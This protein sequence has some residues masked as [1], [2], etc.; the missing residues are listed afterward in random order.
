M[1]KISLLCISIMVGQIL[2]NNGAV[3]ADT[4]FTESQIENTENPATPTS[5]V[6]LPVAQKTTES[7]STSL[8]NE[9]DPSTSSDSQLNTTEGMTTET[10]TIPSAEATSKTTVS[11][12]KSIINSVWGTSPVTFDDTTGIL[13]IMAG[14]LGTT[15]QFPNSTITIT[16]VKEIVIEPGVI[17]PINSSYLFGVGGDTGGFKGVTNILGLENLDVSSV[18]NMHGMFA[19]VPVQNFNGIN[20]WDTSKVKDM[21]AMFSRT[22]AQEFNINSWDTTSVTSMKEMFWADSSL[23][24]L[25]LSSWNVVNV[26]DMTRMFTWA[27]AL[28]ELNISGWNTQPSKNLTQMFMGTSSLSKLVLGTNTILNSTTALPAIDTTSGQYSGGWERISPVTPSS[29]YQSSDL[30]MTNYDGSAPGTYVWQ[31]TKAAVVAKDSTLHVG[32]AWNAED[33]FVSATDAFGNPLSFSD[34]TVTGTVDTSKAGVYPITYTNGSVS[35][36]INVTVDDLS[37]IKAKDSTLHVGDTW[38][39]EDNFI[40]ATDALGNPLSFSD[41]TVTG[42]VDTSKAG[43]YPITYTNGSVSQ[44]INVTVLDKADLSAIK[45][46]DSTLHV[47]DI[48]KAEDNFI[49]ATDALGNP[50]SFS[51]VTVTGTVD[52]SKAGVYPITYTNGSVSQTINVTVL[53][54]ADLSTIKAKD[55]TLHVGDTWKAEDNF[56]SATDPSGTPLSFSDVTVTGTVD[57]SKAGVYPITYTN[58]SVSQTINVTVLDKATTPFSNSKPSNTSTL[59][60]EKVENKELPKTGDSNSSWLISMLGMMLII[61][62]GVISAFSYKKK[63][64]K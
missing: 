47:G 40:S 43:V 9:P 39:A 2:I 50:L 6:D 24:Q 27:S 14:N 45:A 53:D 20:N 26:T 17:P 38:K 55:S 61:V 58:G 5:E 36:T 52:T 37:A 34:V 4:T 63:Q 18:T 22:R 19:D 46:K 21:S 60:A 10:N 42:T 30:F 32:D 41:V 56:I 11:A 3:V 23:T 25:D 15:Y 7:T 28:Q 33:N 1:K 16:D 8:V 59:T 44:T 31:T 64:L 57:T 35:Q 62:L 54:K 29:V 13:T 49:S 48:W 51:D 12:P